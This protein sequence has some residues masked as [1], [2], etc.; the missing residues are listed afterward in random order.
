MNAQNFY[1]VSRNSGKKFIFVSMQLSLYLQSD[2]GL[3]Y[4]EVN[5]NKFE[6]ENRIQTKLGYYS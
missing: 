4:I 6:Y 1:C 3:Y 2:L 5:Q